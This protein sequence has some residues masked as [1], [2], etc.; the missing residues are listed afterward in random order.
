MKPAVVVSL[1]A[2]FVSLSVCVFFMSSFQVMFDIAMMAAIVI[3]MV[4]VSWWVFR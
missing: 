4:T 1:D 2:R 3:W